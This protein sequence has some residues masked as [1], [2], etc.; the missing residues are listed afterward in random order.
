MR[1][2]TLHFPEAALPTVAPCLKQTQEA[3]VCR[4]AQAVR[5]VVPG[6]RLPTVSDTRHCTYAALRQW[7]PRFA[8]QG[9]RGLADRPRPGR[10]PKVTAALAQHL[11]RLVAQDPL[12]HGSTHAQWR[13]QELATVLARPGASSVAKA[14]APA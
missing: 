4:R 8:A 1:P 3:R 14:C 10:P 13:G 5:E 7:V 2:L 6:P 12:P 9:S 11:D